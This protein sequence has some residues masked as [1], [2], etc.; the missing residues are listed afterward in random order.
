MLIHDVLTA[1]RGRNGNG[2]RCRH[3]VEGYGTCPQHVGGE[4]VG[5]PG[6][7]LLKDRINRKKVE[8]LEKA[9]VREKKR[10]EEKLD[11]KHVAEAESLDRQPQAYRDKADS[12]VPVFGKDGA[13]DVM[14]EDVWATLERVGYTAT[15]A[16][17]Y[18]QDKD[19]Q[20]GMATL[21]V[22]FMLG[23]HDEIDDKVAVAC[24]ASFKGKRKFVHVWSNPPKP[25]IGPTCTV[26]CSHPQEDQLPRAR[27]VWDE[28]FWALET[29]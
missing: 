7:I 16:H 2:S 12:G 25:G 24:E 13:K 22:E 26:N 29:V 10:D 5:P 8:V 15:D 6:L 11:A 18:R 27:L 17:F 14:V 20:S 28:G 9:G 23:E 19:A 21:V 4:L 1:C 3:I